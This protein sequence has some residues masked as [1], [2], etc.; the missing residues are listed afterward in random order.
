MDTRTKH[1]I[2]QDRWIVAEQ[3]TLEAERRKSASNLQL[4][5]F[6]QKQL[7]KKLA[8]LQS[9]LSN[10]TLKKRGRS[11]SEV[12]FRRTRRSSSWA[13]TLPIHQQNVSVSLNNSNHHLLALPRVSGGNE[14][15][16]SIHSDGDASE[17]GF[18][19]SDFDSG[20]DGENDVSLRTKSNF[21]QITSKNNFPQRFSKSSDE[22]NKFLP[23][24]VTI[25]PPDDDLLFLYQ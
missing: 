20:E 4:L 6:E 13:D 10:R 23:P 18:F 1:T 5:E 19:T 7:E 25:F 21:P 8:V 15:R 24:L 14:R 16:F 11:T 2:A 22:Q 12:L 3:R 9:Q 17:T